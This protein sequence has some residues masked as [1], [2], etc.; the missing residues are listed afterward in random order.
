MIDFWAQFVKSGTPAAAG[1]PDW[2][3]LTADAGP[4]MSLQPD[5]NRII[6][7]FEHNHRCAFWAGLRR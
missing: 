5:G 1:Q 6:T 3:R 2:P 4:R 7:D